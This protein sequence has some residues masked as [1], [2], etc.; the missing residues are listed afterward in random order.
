MPC[1]PRLTVRSCRGRVDFVI[2]TLDYA[3]IMRAVPP[4]IASGRGGGEGTD[5]NPGPQVPVDRPP[6][7][8]NQQCETDTI[9]KKSGSQQQRA[10]DKYHCPVDKCFGRVGLPREGRSEILERHCPLRTHQNCSKN[11]GDNDDG[12][13]G[14]ET[15]KS[16]NL[17]EQ[18]DLNQRHA[19]KREK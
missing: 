8:R 12:K 5:L 13:S 3:R 9:R 16:A 10:G 7:P 15:D 14:P 19:E 4:R 11:G 1:P 17:N 6:D 18:R 2:I